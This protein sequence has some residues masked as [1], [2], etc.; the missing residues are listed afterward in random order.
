MS[1]LTAYDKEI[2][3]NCEFPVSIPNA[4]GVQGR[5]G[6]NRQILL[7][8]HALRSWLST[9]HRTSSDSMT[10]TTVY[11]SP[12]LM[13]RIAR[14]TGKFFRCNFDKPGSP[15]PDD[16]PRCSYLFAT[17]NAG[18]EGWMM[19]L[20]L[21]NDRYKARGVVKQLEAGARFAE[22]VVSEDIKASFLPVLVFGRPPN[23]TERIELK[24]VSKVSFH[25][26][27]KT[28]KLMKCGSNLVERL[29]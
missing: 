6:K 17:G 13:Q 5:H 24:S 25:G 26:K 22:T 3:R 2:Y 19:P 4:P 20:K 18:D 11:L 14:P 21:K 29:W 10:S 15:L 8:Q 16:R 28:I 12:P 9:L 7:R 27:T 23:K 1:K